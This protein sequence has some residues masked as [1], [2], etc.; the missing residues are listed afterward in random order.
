MVGLKDPGL[1]TQMKKKWAAAG[2]WVLANSLAGQT[3]GV[4]AM[5]M[6]LQSTPTGVV[7]AIIAVSPIIVIPMA[8]FFE[9]ERPTIHSLFGGLVAVGGVIALALRK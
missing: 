3:L 6:A 4:S 5:Q 8:Y 9:G 7:L 1:P 2:P